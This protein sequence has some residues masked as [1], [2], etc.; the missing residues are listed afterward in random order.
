MGGHGHWRLWESM[1]S[2]SASALALA[3]AI[4]FASALALA[5]ALAPCLSPRLSQPASP[6]PSWD[7]R[8]P[9][10]SQSAL[11]S[12]KFTNLEGT[13]KPSMQHLPGAH[14]FSPKVGKVQ[15]VHFPRKSSLFSPKIIDLTWE[16]IRAGAHGSLGGGKVHF[17]GKVRKVRFDRKS[18]SQ[19]SVKSL[20]GIICQKVKIFVNFKK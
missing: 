17:S 10:C 19:P 20:R 11:W 9:K 4:A 15:K 5:S 8:C 6:G 16:N 12:K 3:S 1:A 14:F 2:P 13:A 7:P 18:S